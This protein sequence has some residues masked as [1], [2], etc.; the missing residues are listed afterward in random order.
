MKVPVGTF[1]FS[2]ILDPLGKATRKDQSC[3]S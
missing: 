1:L 3:H 2:K